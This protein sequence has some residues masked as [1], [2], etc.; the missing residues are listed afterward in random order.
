[1]TILGPEW[2]RVN[3]S[4]EARVAEAIEIMNSPSFLSAGKNP[5]YFSCRKHVLATKVSK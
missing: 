4:C 5:R 1:M 3:G 2:E